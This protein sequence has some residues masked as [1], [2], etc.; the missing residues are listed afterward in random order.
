MMTSTWKAAAL[1][2]LAAVAGGSA[3]SA[4]TAR[5]SEGPERRGYGWYIELLRNELD[6]TGAQEDSVRA[7]LR[8]R[9]QTMDSLWAEIR[10]RFDAARSAVRAEIAGQLTTA[11]Q[12]RFAEV[13]ARLDAERQERQRREQA[14][15]KKD[16]EH[17]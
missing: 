1:L 15:K 8:R 5:R 3:G 17:N 4:W 12:T 2:A 14:A 11:Q 7:I 13:G 6:L 9:D 16:T 10:P